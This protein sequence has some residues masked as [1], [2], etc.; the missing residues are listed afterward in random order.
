[1]LSFCFCILRC[2]TVPGVLTYLTGLLERLLM[3]K[4]S[5]SFPRIKHHT[6]AKKKKKHMND[7]KI[8]W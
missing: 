7:F 8:A 2:E 3:M 6:N 4:I 5:K 1:M